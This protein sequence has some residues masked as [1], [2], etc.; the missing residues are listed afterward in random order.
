MYKNHYKQYYDKS[1]KL[2]SNI[3]LI[4]N[5]INNFIETSTDL[6][7]EISVLNI[8][9]DDLKDQLQYCQTDDHT[10]KLQTDVNLITTTIEQDSSIKLVYLQYLLLY[11]INLTNGIFMDIYLQEAQQILDDNGGKLKHI[12]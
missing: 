11:D 10:T 6:N 5:K 4:A 8:V 7:K 9:I 3:Q 12:K 1:K 2:D